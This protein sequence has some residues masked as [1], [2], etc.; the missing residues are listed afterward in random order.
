[1]TTLVCARIG[2]AALALLATSC[3]DDNK[4]PEGLRLAN[5]S[6]GP[7]IRFDLDERPFPEIPFPNDV[8]TRPDPTS[9][10]GLR[11]N[12][13]ER[14]GSDAE[15]AV[16]HAINQQ[17][18]FGVYSPISV[19]FDAPIDVEELIRRHH[20]KIPDLSDDAVYLVNID[21]KSPEYGKLELLDLGQGSFPLT[22][23]N[24]GRYFANDPRA[25]GTNLIMETVAE[26][27]AD[28]NGKLDP[29]EDTDDDGVWDVP[30]VRNKGANPLTPGQLLEFYER[31]SN[32][33]I[34]RP[35]QPLAPATTYAVVLT[36]AVRG[37]DGLPID[38][39]FEAIN[40]TR[41]TDALNALRFILPSALP[42]R[43]DPALG[44][45]RFAWSFTT[46]QPTQILEAVR[47][48]LYGQGALSWLDQRFPP[49]LHM[50]HRAIP[51]DAPG[52]LSFKVDRLI[53]LL[54]PVISQAAG[55]ASGRAI[56]ESFQH[57]DYVVSGTFISPNFLIDKD[58]LATS[59]EEAPTDDP[60]AFDQRNRADDDEAFDIDLATGE[61]SV[62]RGE[63]TFL[64]MVPKETA[65]HKAPFKTIL[66]SH[67]ISSTRLESLAFAGTMA[68][69]GLAT[70]AIDAVGHGIVIPEEFESV[71]DTAARNLR[72]PGLPTILTH[73]RAR[74]INNDG[75]PDS[76]G[77]Y[78]TSDLLHS[79][80]NIRQTTIDQLQFMRIL[81]GFDGKRRFPAKV[82]EQDPFIKARGGFVA[83]WDNDADGVSELAGDFN[84]DGVPDLGGEATYVSWGTSLGGIQDALISGV[85]PTIRTTALNAGGGGL[86]DIA[87]RTDISQVRVGVMLRMMGPVLVGEPADGKTRLTWLLPDGLD[88][89]RVPFA[90]IDALEEGDRV[91]LRNLRR[92]K[93]ALVPL[94]EKRSHALVRGGRFRVAIG[95]DATMGTERRAHLGFDSTYDLR[96]VGLGCMDDA[97][98]EAAD[99]STLT[100]EGKR[101]VLAN[102]RDEGDP[103]VIEIYDARGELK[104]TIDTFPRT[105]IFQNILYPAGAPLAA[106][107]Q[108]WGLK[109]QTPKF[110]RFLG[111]GAMLLEPADPAIWASHYLRRPLEF[112]YE[113]TYASG[114]TNALVVGTLG[115]QTVPISTG[116]G[117]AR[118]AG[119][120]NMTDPDPR[121]GVPQNQRLI[122]TF[123]YEGI[124]WLNRL[125]GFPGAIADPDNLDEGR[126]RSKRQPDNAR[127]NYD[128]SPPMRVQIKTP[129]WGG[130]SALRLPYL[131][132]Q[133]EH[134]FNAPNPDLP[135]D[136]HTYMLNQVGYYLATGG[137]EVRDDLCLEADLEMSMCTFFDIDT[138]TP[139]F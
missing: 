8:A 110:R 49:D 121:Y 43:F 61:A 83:G 27:D 44:N 97:C 22:M 3:L 113:T 73:H 120:I 26:V 50:I 54:A 36:S 17:T 9:P 101:H 126:F 75:V 28:G 18:G 119:I 125:V 52:P 53:Q 123:V 70:C 59:P 76:G 124:W 60:L 98:V 7:R 104:R 105:T 103:L 56:S 24:P 57:I 55:Q 133:G 80:D 21:T 68:K 139:R 39:P 134:T 33:L 34:V 86:A 79:R 100:E 82:D 4:M 41:Q 42:G 10:T 90:V 64:C 88:E 47:A 63:V 135:F 95:A 115:D 137:Q 102:P 30:N 45:V 136:I 81:R 117:I 29:I 127:I 92:E 89:G 25:A 72:L 93:N 11:I 78:F 5:P 1:M 6:G 132:E 99:V 13:S 58:G 2:I 131:D 111:I 84:G 108:G 31:E 116:I 67:A 122:D 46:Q 138:F 51:E 19:S 129:Y 109:R 20:Q 48:G 107:T 71:L 114:A 62:G 112:P 65:T 40:H 91:L 16:R 37:A 12:V 106:M 85:E 128:E 130:V 14:G 118:S 74:D 87:M 15:E 94:D 35:L 66:Y 96:G 69:F 23:L 32:T 77:D 38:S